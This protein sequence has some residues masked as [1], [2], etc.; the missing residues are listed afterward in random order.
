MIIESILNLVF[1]LIKFIFGW[2]SLPA[3]PEE[4]T[5]TI[6]SFFDII[7]SNV[8]LLGFFIRPTTLQIL[9]PVLI[10]VLNFEKIYKFVMWIVKKIPMLN[11]K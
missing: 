1:S 9:V 11:I 4:L 2:L 6:N 7:F 10:I 3:F 5:N 8:S